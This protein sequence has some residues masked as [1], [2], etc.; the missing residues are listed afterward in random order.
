MLFTSVGTDEPRPVTEMGTFDRE[1]GIE[2]LGWLV[3][4][5]GYE[6]EGEQMAC[7]P[8]SGRCYWIKERKG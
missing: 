6:W 1:T 2:H 7:H 5:C 8:E 3:A 4:L